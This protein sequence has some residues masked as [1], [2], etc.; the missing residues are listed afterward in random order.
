MVDYLG[1]ADELKQA[2]AIYTEA[3]GIGK[4]ALDQA[5][6]VALMLEKHEVCRG[7]FHGF[8]FAQWINGKAQDRLSLLPA[9]QEH[10][11]AQQ[12]GKKRLMDRVITRDVTKLAVGQVYYTPWCDPHGKII[13]DGE[14][15]FVRIRTDI[16]SGRSLATAPVPAIRTVRRG[17]AQL[18]APSMSAMRSRVGTC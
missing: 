8:D 2:L 15:S 4:T 14:E 12:D 11:L 17:S 1:L 7:L 18:A 9:A 13:D 10:I 5:E 16:V 3:G 6:A